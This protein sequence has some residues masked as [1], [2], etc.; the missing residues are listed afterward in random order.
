MLGRAHFRRSSRFLAA[1]LAGTALFTAGCGSPNSPTIIIPS[2]RV[3]CPAN[4]PAPTSTN[5]LAVPVSFAA[6]T[7]TG[8]TPPVTVTCAPASGSPF[9]VGSTAVSCTATD[10][11]QRTSDCTFAVTVS[12]PPAH[13]NVTNFLAY[14]DSITAS[15]IPDCMDTA[16]AM[17]LV[18]SL[19]YP[20]QLE[21]MLEQRYMLQTFTVNADGSSGQTASGDG[22]G[23]ALLPGALSRYHPE[24]LILLEG[25][26]D[27][28]VDDPAGSSQA[29]LSALQ[30]MIIDAQSQNVRVIISTLLPEVVGSEPGARVSSESAMLIQPFNVRLVQM[31]QAQ[32]AAVVDMYTDFI[33][34]N[35]TAW[36]S[37][38]DGL[39]PTAAGY[40]EMARVFFN[41]IKGAY[42][43]PQ[44]PTPTATTSSLVPP[45][46]F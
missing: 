42:E 11:V 1:G 30:S 6:P 16:C 27:L 34:G 19:G 3:S 9:V 44:S 2:P 37:P 18:P 14:G 8:G 32:G 41:A 24:V 20:A 39:H 5:G 46:H 10:A 33:N 31:A 17:A 28:S 36:I 35:L 38:L 12:P 4:P 15:E 22:G 7:V 40:Q 26:N 13:L 21:T 25:V 45:K 43:S 29:A 23:A